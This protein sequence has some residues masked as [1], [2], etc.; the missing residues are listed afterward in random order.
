MV[1]LANAELQPSERKPSSTYSKARD[2]DVGKQRT[3]INE[4]VHPHRPSEVGIRRAEAEASQKE[5]TTAWRYREM[6]CVLTLKQPRASTV[7]EAIPS[8]CGLE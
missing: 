1:D 6:V 2:R 3:C 5:E 7:K 4:R 8:W